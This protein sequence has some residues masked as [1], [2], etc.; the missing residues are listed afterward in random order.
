MKACADQTMTI[1][2]PTWRQNLI[3]SLTRHY[4]FL[5]GRTRIAQSKL[6]RRL[7]GDRGGLVWAPVTGGEILADIDDFVGRSAFFTGD[8]DR[9][10]TLI[11]ERIVR[12]GDVV[13]D[14]GANVGVYTLT[15]A[16]NC[17]PEG[18][19][20]AFEPNPKLVDILS[21][22]IEHNHL[23]NVVLHPVALGAEGADR[24]LSVPSRNKGAGSL[25]RRSDTALWDSVVVPVR[26]LDDMLDVESVRPIRFIKLD[27]EGFEVDVC[28]GASKMFDA[29]PPQAILFEANDPRQG[30][31]DDN[32]MIGLL[33]AYDYAFFEVATSLFRLRLRPLGPGR[34]IGGHDVLAVA[35]GPAFDE[36]IAALPIY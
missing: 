7:A 6:L 8:L 3:A 11:M 24:E 22:L 21:Q 5:S 29:S 19:V 34:R 9:K 12:P 13:L 31:F 26:R 36:I 16:K 25:I 14:I 33:S 4:P 27:V 2:I 35:K 17:S 28:R 18:R 23:G 1:G 20:L 15:L 30:S 32:P 10:L